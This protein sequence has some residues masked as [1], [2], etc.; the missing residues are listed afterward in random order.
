MER[1]FEHEPQH[2]VPVWISGLLWGAGPAAG[3]AWHG[4]AWDGMAG[5]HMGWQGSRQALAWQAAA[6]DRHEDGV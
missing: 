5:P 2:S 4:M 3:T 1:V 6:W